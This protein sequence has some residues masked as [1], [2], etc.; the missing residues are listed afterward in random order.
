MTDSAMI[1]H[2]SGS[3]LIMRSN[4]LMFDLMYRSSQSHNNQIRI[5][6]LEECDNNRNGRY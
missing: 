6:F 1:G 3:T 4:D 5:A 2:T